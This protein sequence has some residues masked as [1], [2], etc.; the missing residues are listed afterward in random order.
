[1]SLILT[2]QDLANVMRT[3]EDIK[4]IEAVLCARIG[5]PSPRREPNNTN[6]PVILPTLEDLLIKAV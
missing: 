6:D 1:V 4:I 5:I 2:F 3:V